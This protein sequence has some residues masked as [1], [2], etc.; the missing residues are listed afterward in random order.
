MSAPQFLDIW[1]DDETSWSIK[2]YQFNWG[3]GRRYY[4]FRS[5]C[6][7]AFWIPVATIT[8]YMFLAVVSVYS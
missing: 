5:I 8:A 1:T 6:R 2:A 7:M 4:K 3:L